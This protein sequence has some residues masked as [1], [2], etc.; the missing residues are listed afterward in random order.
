MYN[1]R[2]IIKQYPR[3]FVGVWFSVTPVQ[4]CSL[5]QGML[6]FHKVGQLI[7]QSDQQQPQ[8]YH[9]M[10]DS[11]LTKMLVTKRQ[12]IPIEFTRNFLF[13][14][15]LQW[16]FSFSGFPEN[17]NLSTC[18]RNLSRLINDSFYESPT[19]LPIHSIYVHFRVR[20]NSYNESF[21]PLTLV[22][23]LFSWLTL[24]D[25]SSCNLICIWIW[26]R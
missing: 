4:I 22:L 24:D 25:Y 26:F 7:F 6:S 3:K 5:S 2:H 19:T 16:P 1:L 12:Q 9:Q 15:L 10:L 8:V 23:H 17:S 13:L 14:V 20:S 18:T 21:I 11:G